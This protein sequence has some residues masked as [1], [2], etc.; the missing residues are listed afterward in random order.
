MR[1]FS[2]LAAV[3]FGFS[4][5]FI[6][7]AKPV[8]TEHYSR[9]PA[10][11]DAAL[12][13]DGRF[14][15]TVVDNNGKYIL[16]VFYIADPSDKKVR[17]SSYPKEVKVNWV[18][19]ANNDQI[20]LSTRQTQKIDGTIVYT[21][22]LYVLG[23]DASDAKIVLKPQLKSGKLGSQADNSGGY[24]QFNNT[25][26]DF[27]P[28]DT[29]H[30]LMSFGK[31]NAFTPGVHK[32][33]IKTRRANRI[34][35]GSAEIQYWI[36]DLRGEVR[37][38][39]G[40]KE[41]TGDWRMKIRDANG[42]TWRTD[43]DYPGL[44]VGTS[45]YGFTSNPNEMIIGARAGKDTLGLFIYDLAQKKRTRKLFQHDKYDVDG[46][47]ISADG[48]QVVGARYTDDTTKR[49]FFDTASKSRMAKIQRE[50]EGYQINIIEQ[51]RNGN[52]VLFKANTP[53]V[54]P[55]LYVYDFSKNQST[56]LARDY[57]E[58]G[59]TDQGDVTKVRY[60]ARDG[61]KIPGYVTTP[62]KIGA[63]EIALKEQPFIIMPHG[64]PY[65]RDTKSFDYL[66]QFMASRGYSVLQ[67]N[68]SGSEGFGHA[69]ENA[70][71]K[72]WEIMQEDVEDG[73]RWLIKKG[74]ADKDRVCIV[75]WSYGGYAALMGAIKDPGLY[76]CAASIAGVTD[77]QD[78]IRDLKKYRFG[79][80]TAKHFILK[81]F[82][83]KKDIKENSPV[84]RAKEITTPLF[85]AHGTDDV[86]VHF[87]QFTR[88]KKAL[89]KSKA[90]TTFLEFQDED[91]YFV[92][93]ENRTKLLKGLDKFLADNLGESAAAP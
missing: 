10:V 13:P 53:S 14:L 46:I 32:V 79:K 89:K 42:N 6:A 20:L 49:A 11:Y 31:D 15:A 35:R 54:P 26:V 27:L 41:R 3:L 87:D 90:K 40:R 9:T 62:A 73:A 72:N 30:I 83:G 80:H 12:S 17:A 74:Y 18:H 85:L 61:F 7:W 24:R 33:N 43:K 71:R 66:A 44:E 51:T 39:T 2:I 23:K 36:T 58:I 57:P 64:G 52:Q 77:L 88:M 55:N 37:V 25:V 82:D 48:K 21:G 45:V 93:Y 68:F 91:H 67:M 22:F 56:F 70:G 92:D 76:T 78:M 34:E 81:G 65:A 16:R 38:G 63:G 8:P 4:A 60:T 1:L 75:G 84:K 28:N 47:I 69:H 29:D 50:F 86:N 59:N 19:W 5:A